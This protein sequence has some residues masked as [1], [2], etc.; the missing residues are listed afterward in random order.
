MESITAWLRTH[1]SKTGLLSAYFIADQESEYY[2][3]EAFNKVLQWVQQSAGKV[4][5]KEKETRQ[6]LRLRLAIKEVKSVAQG[7]AVLP[8]L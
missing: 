1:H 5:L 8:D 3:S 7:L 4:E 2:Q 6:G